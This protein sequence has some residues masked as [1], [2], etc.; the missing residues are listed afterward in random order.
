MVLPSGQHGSHEQN[1]TRVGGVVK[2][3]CTLLKENV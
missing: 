1:V 3:V 2:D